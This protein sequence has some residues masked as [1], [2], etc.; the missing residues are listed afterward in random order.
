M[1][2]PAKPTL[3]DAAPER[4]ADGAR[5]QGL[6]LEPVSDRPPAPPAA[7][8]QSLWAAFGAALVL[9]VGA[10]AQWRRGR[11]RAAARSTAA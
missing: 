4:P 2:R 3:A 7:V 1:Q 9:A 11:A 5:V 10:V 8:L 6:K